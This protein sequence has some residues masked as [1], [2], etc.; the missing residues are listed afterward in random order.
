VADRGINRDALLPIGHS[1]FYR[2][3]RPPNPL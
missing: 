2:E 3:C 1:S